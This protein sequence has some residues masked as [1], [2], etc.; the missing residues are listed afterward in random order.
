MAKLIYNAKV[1][2]ARETFAEAVLIKGSYIAAI[3]SNDEMLAAASAGTEHIDAQGKLLLP[4]FHDCHQHLAMTGREAKTVHADVSSIEELIIQGKDTIAALNPSQNAFITGMGWDDNKLGRYP[5]RKDLDRISTEYA[6]VL[7]R[8]CGHVICCN[9]LALER[10]GI[11]SHGHSGILREKEAEPVWNAIPQESETETLEHI[12]YAVQNAL[13]SGIT[14]VASNDVRGGDVDKFVRIFTELYQN[15]KLSIRITE[16]CAIDQEKHL[17]EYIDKGYRTGSQLIPGL[18]KFGPLKLFADGSLGSKTAL[19][20]K[21]YQDEPKSRGIQV[22]SPE[23]L[24]RYVKK[25]ADNGIQVAT[26]AIGDGAV[27]HVVSSYEAVTTTRSNPLR[28]GVIHSQITDIPLLTRMAANNILALIQPIFLNS[29]RHIIESRVGHELA[30]TSYAWRTMEQLGIRTAYGT[31]S[32]VE[33]MNPIENIAAAVT[34]YGY[35][36]EECVDVYTAV[37]AYTAGTA[38]ANFDENRFGRIKTGLLADLVLL[39]TDIFSVPIESIA[40]TRVLFTMVGGEI[41]YES[42]C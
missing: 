21:P 24:N 39:D 19:L 1:Y 11:D 4:G 14:A 9:S 25:A 26:H 31:D 33:S 28:H 35:F 15:K 16:Q 41:V 6:V 40:D 38:Y 7:S 27:D 32:P 23:V 13:A 34:R 20:R 8:R 18:L 29:D 42:E 17:D 37:D 2:L 5:T 3:G 30:S 36:P 22:L 12:R 10:A